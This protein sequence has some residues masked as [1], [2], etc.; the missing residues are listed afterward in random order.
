MPAS[1]NVLVPCPDS[2][3]EETKYNVYR[4][5]EIIFTYNY[6]VGSNGSTSGPLFVRMGMEP[7]QNAKDTLVGFTLS[8]VN[9]SSR[10]IYRCEG[11]VTFPPPLLQLQSQQWI[12]VLIE[13]KYSYHQ[14]S[15]YNLI[16]HQVQSTRNE[17]FLVG[18]QCNLTCNSGEQ[19]CGFH[20]KWILAL[21]VLY[22]TIATI[23]A[24]CY[25]VSY[26][27]S[28]ESAKSTKKRTHVF[29]LWHRDNFQKCLWP[30]RI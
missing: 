28:A 21:V 3:G 11:T 23:C 14:G 7:Y 9:I 19:D 20:W 25:R 4:N 1:D 5:N 2:T 17:C 29:F 15:V 26:L 8:R 16:V 12:L 6:N 18:H 27:S 13:G 30:I 24:I 22:S 10:G